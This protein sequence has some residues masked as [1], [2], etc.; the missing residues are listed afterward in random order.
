MYLGENRGNPQVFAQAVIDAGADIVFG[1]GPHVPRAIDLYK[2][3]FIAY[4]LGNFATYA[5]FNLKSYA[6]YAP[7]VTIKL[8]QKGDFISGEII[9]FIQEG[10]GGPVFDATNKAALD[11]KSLTESDLP[12]CPLQI[13]ETGQITRKIN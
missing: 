3:K 12:S 1:H 6:G 7:L 2:N 13:S 4:S 11:I 9:S 8:N 10:E 5:R